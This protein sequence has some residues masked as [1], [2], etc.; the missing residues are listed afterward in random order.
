MR[1]IQLRKAEDREIRDLHKV[2]QQRGED[3]K[4]PALPGHPNL[5]WPRGRAWEPR[6]YRGQQ[7]KLLVIGAEARPYVLR[8]LYNAYESHI[9]DPTRIILL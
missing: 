5:W 6:H 2:T 7:A 4:E 9:D 1:N 8:P 3:P